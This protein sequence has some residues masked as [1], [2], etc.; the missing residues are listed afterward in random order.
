MRAWILIL[1]IGLSGLYGCSGSSGPGPT[2]PTPAPVVAR[3]VAAFV[4]VEETADAANDRGAFLMDP[5][6]AAAI[7]AQGL[8][9]L[10]FDKD[11]AADPAFPAGLQGYA[12]RAAGQKL[13]RVFLTDAAGKLLFEG[14]LPASPADFVA[15]LAKFKG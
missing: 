7:K 8:L 15:L 5:G 10:V 6:L 12:K 1:A 2:P 9:H 11:A 14:D 4:I 3:P 13:P